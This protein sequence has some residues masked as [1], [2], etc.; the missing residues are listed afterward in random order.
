MTVAKIPSS[1][2]G[3]MWAASSWGRYWGW[4]P[5]EVWSLIAFLA[6]LAIL[7]LRVDR[8]RT[9]TWVFVVAAGLGVVLLALIV[10]K[11]APM[12]PGDCFYTMLEA[13]RIAVKYMTPVIVLSDG[14]IANASEPWLLPDVDTLPRFPVA[15]AALSEGFRPFARDPQTLARSWAVPGTR[16]RYSRPPGIDRKLA[17]WPRSAGTAPGV[18][19]PSGRWHPW[20]CRTAP[21]QWNW[22]VRF[23]MCVN[24]MWGNLNR[25]ANSG[26]G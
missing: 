25:K 23:A 7:H 15:F 20:Q 5:K 3:S 9:P 21:N 12:T 4:D 26:K 13:F 19:L 14:Y 6:Y 11:L 2:T 10:P 17:T 18:S 24:G 8:E 1:P 16:I 22:S